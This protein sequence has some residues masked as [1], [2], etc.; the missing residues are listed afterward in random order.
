MLMQSTS[1]TINSVLVGSKCSTFSKIHLWVAFT[2]IIKQV[3]TIKDQGFVGVEVVG[4]ITNG[5]KEKRIVMRLSH[6]NPKG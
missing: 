6:K 5:D 3:V 1:V 4:A 2:K